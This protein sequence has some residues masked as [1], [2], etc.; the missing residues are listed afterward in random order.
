MSIMI[1]RIT[2]L[3]TFPYCLEKQIDLF[4]A[5]VAR[6]DKP[7]MTPGRP[8][9]I[10]DE[11]RIDTGVEESLRESLDLCDGPWHSHAGVS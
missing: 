8:P 1:W 6:Y 2:F 9:W 11:G 3:H 4:V 10:G 7:E 5:V